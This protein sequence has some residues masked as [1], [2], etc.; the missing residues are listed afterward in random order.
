MGDAQKLKK[1]ENDVNEQLTL[2]YYFS[3]VALLTFHCLK[4]NS[5][6]LKHRRG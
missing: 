2:F 5:H 1:A 6:A 4:K 3:S